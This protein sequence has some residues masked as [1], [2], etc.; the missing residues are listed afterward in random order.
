MIT[1]IRAS[2]EVISGTSNLGEIER[3]L[4]QPA[5]QWNSLITSLQYLVFPTSH[6]IICGGMAMST[7]D[8][9]CMRKTSQGQSKPTS[10]AALPC[11]PLALYILRFG[12]IGINLSPAAG[13][14]NSSL[15]RT[16]TGQI[17]ITA[18]IW[19]VEAY[20]QTGTHGTCGRNSGLEVLFPVDMPG[21][22]LG[23]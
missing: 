11:E 15:P 12:E 2:A 14:G 20:F 4:L 13:A 1:V 7:S 18:I 5:A 23:M 3:A 21:L 16:S 22:I 8:Q 9:R 19:C 10:E 17:Q 6:I